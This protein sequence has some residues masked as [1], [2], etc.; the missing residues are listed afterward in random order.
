MNQPVPQVSSQVLDSGFKAF[1]PSQLVQFVEF[2]TQDL[3]GE[4]QATQAEPCT[5]NL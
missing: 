5:K 2:P 1:V 4:V 3:Q